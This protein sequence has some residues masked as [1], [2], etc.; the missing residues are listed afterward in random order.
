M[1]AV[2][3]AEIAPMHLQRAADDD[4]GQRIREA[5]TAP[6]AMNSSRPPTI[7]GLRPMRSDSQPSGMCRKACI[8]P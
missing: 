5:A 2:M 7:T 3:A 6:P 1:Q 8:R 4:A